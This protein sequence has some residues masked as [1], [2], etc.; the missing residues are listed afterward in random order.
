MYAEMPAP[1]YEKEEH[2]PSVENF[3]N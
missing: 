3:G 2:H 1:S